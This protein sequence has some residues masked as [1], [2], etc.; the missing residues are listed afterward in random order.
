MAQHSRFTIVTDASFQTEVIAHPEPVLVVFEADWSGACHIAGPAIEALASE[1]GD[2]IKMCRL[3][4]DTHPRVAREYGIQGLPTFLFF[5]WGR[6]VDHLVGTVPKAELT[7]R[8]ES[9]LSAS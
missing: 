1:F 9:L 2:R 6:V 8:F 4:V 7:P 5:Q 3:N